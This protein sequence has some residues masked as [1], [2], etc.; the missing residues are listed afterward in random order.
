M[1]LDDGNP[2][3]TQIHATVQ[4]SLRCEHALRAVSGPIHRACRATPFVYL[5]VLYFL[6]DAI[7]QRPVLFLMADACMIPDNRLFPL[8]R[9][10]LKPRRGWHV[11]LLQEAPISR[12]IPGILARLLGSLIVHGLFAF[13]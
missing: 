3:G 12:N 5:S 7:P 10:R 11:L 6:Y 8:R 9:F 13:L 4:P 2:F 1:V